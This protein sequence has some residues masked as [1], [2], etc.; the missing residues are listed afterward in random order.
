MI[1]PAKSSGTLRLLADQID[2]GENIPDYVFAIIHKDEMGDDPHVTAIYTPDQPY[3]MVG[4]LN[5][6]TYSIISRLPI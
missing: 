6:I 4:I 5:Q 2:S 3:R 1:L